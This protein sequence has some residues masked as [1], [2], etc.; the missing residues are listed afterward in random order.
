[1]KN[2]HRFGAK[3]GSGSDAYLSS[4]SS[5]AHGISIWAS[6]ERVSSWSPGFIRSSFPSGAQV[7]PHEPSSLEQLRRVKMR[8]SNK[9]D[10]I[11]IPCS[12]AGM[13]SFF[14]EVALF[15]S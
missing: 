11:E 1:M 6:V 2:E 12:S 5:S 14:L 8:Y 13:G 10:Q 3:D 15:I 9:S 7:G 4:R